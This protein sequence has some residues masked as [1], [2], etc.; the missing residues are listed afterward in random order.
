MT[1]THLAKV[2]ENKKTATVGDIQTKLK[3]TNSQPR[4]LK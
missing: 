4:F 3:I 1:N 2:I